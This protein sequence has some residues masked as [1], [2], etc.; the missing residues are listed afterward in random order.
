MIGLDALFKK[1]ARQHAI[2]HSTLFPQVD[3]SLPYLISTDYDIIASTDNDIDAVAFADRLASIEPRG[4]R[5]VVTFCGIG[6]YTTTGWS[7][8]A[9]HGPRPVMKGF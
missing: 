9:D 5:I 2:K 6:F 7:D 8:D 3:F 4:S 1:G